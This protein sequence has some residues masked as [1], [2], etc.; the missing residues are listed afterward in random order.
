VTAAVLGVSHL[1]SVLVEAS[2]ELEV[3]HAVRFARRLAVALG[4]AVLDQQT[5]EL[6]RRGRSRAVAKP[7]ARECVDAVSLRWYAPSAALRGSFASDYLALCRRYLPEASPRRFGDYEPLQRRFSEGGDDAFAT[8][9]RSAGRDVIF[10]A[11][12]P[13]CGGMIDPGPENPRPQRVWKMSLNVLRAPLAEAAWRGS[14]RGLFVAA[15]ERFGCFFA[16]AE[17]ERNQIWARG[18]LWSDWESERSISPWFR[19]AWMGLPPYPMWWSYYGPGYRELVTGPIRAAGTPLAHGLFHAWTEEP[20]DR[21]R[22]DEMA[23]DN[24]LSPELL[25]T[26]R[27]HDGGY[28]APPRDPARLIPAELV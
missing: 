5:D 1:Y 4:G 2:A 21:D 16:S 27:P 28:G 18:G 7:A 19:S 3:P 8:F 11:S 26:M 9:W 12:P 13:C 20:A 25:M 6:W 24:W 23:Q 17:V 22:L 14:L 10:T 15:A